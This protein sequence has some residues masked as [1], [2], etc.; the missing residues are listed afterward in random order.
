ML[1]P[2]APT[3]RQF[4]QVAGEQTEAGPASPVKEFVS[5]LKKLFLVSFCSSGC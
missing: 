5:V 4:L 3:A 1:P 2:L